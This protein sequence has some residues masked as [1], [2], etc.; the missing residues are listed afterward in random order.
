[1][2]LT[3]PTSHDVSKDLAMGHLDA[4]KPNMINP[5]CFCASENVALFQGFGKSTEFI[6]M[7]TWPWI[8]ELFVVTHRMIHLTSTIYTGKINRILWFFTTVWTGIFPRQ[9]T[10]LVRALLFSEWSYSCPQYPIHLTWLLYYM[11]WYFCEWFSWCEQA[12]VICPSFT[13]KKRC[14]FNPSLRL[15]IFVFHYLLCIYESLVKTNSQGCSCGV[16]VV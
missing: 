3:P 12:F 13:G 14:G 5:C 1:M 8:S 9:R 6:H 15:G 10:I 11:I 16:W 7:K 2:G 4:R